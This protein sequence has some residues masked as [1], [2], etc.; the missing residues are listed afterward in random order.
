MMEREL[1]G[2]QSSGQGCAAR[3]AEDAAG[4]QQGLR[5]SVR[6]G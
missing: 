6:L 4:K 5:P 2:S 3:Q 1:H